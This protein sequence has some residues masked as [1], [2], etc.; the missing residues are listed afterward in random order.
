[1]IALRYE[2]YLLFLAVEPSRAVGTRIFV[3]A[4]ARALSYLSSHPQTTGCP[5]LVQLRWSGM[6]T[7]TQP[8][9]RVCPLNPTL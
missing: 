5:S 8:P 3:F 2:R 7:L 4:C 6:R 9:G 1:M